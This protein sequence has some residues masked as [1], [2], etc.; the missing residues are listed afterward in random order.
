MVQQSQKSFKKRPDNIQIPIAI[1]PLVVGK[2][3]QYMAKCKPGQ[4]MAKCKPSQYMAKHFH[5]V[6]QPVQ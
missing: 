4:Y 5:F 6:L 1:K 3:S 2:S